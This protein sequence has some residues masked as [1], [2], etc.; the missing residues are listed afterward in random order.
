MGYCQAW[1][2]DE[3]G[4]FRKCGELFAMESAGCGTHPNKEGY[5]KGLNTASI[6]K[7]LNPD[8]FRNPFLEDQ[9][10]VD[11]VADPREENVR[12]VQQNDEDID[13]LASEEGLTPDNIP[14]AHLD[15]ERKKKTD[16]KSNAAAMKSRRQQTRDLTKIAE[17]EA[18]R[19]RER[20]NEVGYQDVLKKNVKKNKKK[21][22][23]DHIAAE[24]AAKD[25][26]KSESWT[27]VIAKGYNRIRR[28][29]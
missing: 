25:Q 3:G 26:A 23:E 28:R 13:R 19:D 4:G 18:R 27:S 6:E 22:M 8:H 29:G 1:M 14:L 5:N 12:I 2:P 15:F 9:E 11:P 17:E 20:Q 24:Q 10:N 21:E 7:Y 16:A